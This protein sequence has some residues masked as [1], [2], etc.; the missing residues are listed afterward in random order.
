MQCLHSR[1]VATFIGLLLMLF[2]HVEATG[3]EPAQWQREGWISDFESGLKQARS[4]DRPAF[5][6][7]DA[8]WCSWCQQYTRDVL[9]TAA[10]RSALARHFVRLVV[11][12]DARPDLM[13]RYGGKGL[14]FT[15]VLSPEGAVLDQFV[16]VLPPEDLVKLLDAVARS[17]S[18][19]VEG[20]APGAVL[21]QPVALDRKGYA[22]FRTAYLR[23]LESLYDPARETISGQF[24]TGVTFRRA[25]LLA[26]LY[27]MDQG[28]WQDRIPLAA[29][30]ERQRLWDSLD[31]GFFNFVDPTRGDYLESSKLLEINAWLAAWQA[32]VGV[33]D[34]QARLVAEQ[35]WHYLRD[36]LWDQV[37]GGF[38]QSQLADN[39]YY[40]LPPQ[41][42]SR[43]PV[44]PVDRAKRTDTNAQAVWAL[45]RLGRATGNEEA[46]GHA[47]QTMNFLLR[48][49][50][51]DGRLYHLWR[52]GRL[53]S[54]DLPHSWFWV[55]AAGA[56][57]E[58]VCPDSWRRQQLAAIAGSAGRW[59][60]QRMRDPDAAPLDIE[61]AGLVAWTAGQRERYPVL[62]VGARDW[63]L[64]QLRIEAETSPDEPVIGLWAW[65]ARL[66][67]EENADEFSA[68]L[69]RK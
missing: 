24:E 38:F 63:A 51:R 68:S 53:S 34:P 18:P 57:L 61:L 60:E 26:W 33:H 46:V 59:L 22:D 58:K 30:A 13:R 69:M 3:F 28:L 49:M 40:A 5:V 65:E 44:P 41:E 43:R 29:R 52:N 66:E 23:H 56:E 12:Y 36:V 8:G 47:A 25:S 19:R 4:T 17:G 54:P 2:G 10:V 62:P 15:V 50:W 67:D 7:F 20:S 55:L 21:H 16:G 32:Q 6:Y 11:D 37:H 1:S 31:K 39:A 14:P 45:L 35:A 42:R 48:E 9:E 27:L 64:A